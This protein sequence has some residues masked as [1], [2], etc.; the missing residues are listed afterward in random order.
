M[1]IYLL[2]AQ[3]AGWSFCWGRP[4]SWRRSGSCASAAV[5]RYTA[6]SAARTPAAAQCTTQNLVSVPWPANL[7]S[8]FRGLQIWA[9]C[10][11]ACSQYFAACKSVP[12]VPRPTN[13][14]SVFR[15]PQICAQCSAAHKSVPR[16]P[17]P[18]T[19]VPRPTNLCSVFRGPQICAQCS[20]AHKVFRGP[21]ICAQCSAAHKSVLNV[22]R[23]TTH[24]A[25]LNYSD[26]TGR[27]INIP[28]PPPHSPWTQQSDLFTRPSAL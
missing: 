19:N 24:V 22:P 2:K 9:Q 14:C 10:S 8:M 25:V 1:C 17:R 15:G 23:P 5:T 18:E 4:P 27:F 6:S 20:A 16:V 26:K 11:A 28:P 13:L 3:K 21:Q 12:S 7:C